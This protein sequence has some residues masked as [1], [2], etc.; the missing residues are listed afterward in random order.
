MGFS[1]GVYLVNPSFNETVPRPSYLPTNWSDCGYEFQSPP[2]IQ[3]SGAWEAPMVPAVEGYTYLSMVTR[4]N[5]TV[6]RVQQELTNPLESGSL[7]IFS[8]YLSHF[9]EFLSGDALYNDSMVQATLKIDSESQVRGGFPNTPFVSYANPIT[10]RI[11]GGNEDCDLD[12][13]LATS[14][15]INHFDWKKYLFLL[16]PKKTYRFFILEAFYG[17]HTKE[18]YSGNIMLDNSELS[19]FPIPDL[20]DNHDPKDIL[21][22]IINQRDSVDHFKNVFYCENILT[23]W[24]FNQNSSGENVLQFIKISTESEQNKMINA[25]HSSLLIDNAFALEELIFEWKNAS[26]DDR[27]KSFEKYKESIS[28][29][30]LSV[31]ILTYI[32]ENKELILKELMGIYDK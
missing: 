13:L 12:E 31:G 32:A 20:A 25:L 1:Q 24:D 21:S 26:E 7:Y 18:P 6:E 17:D 30:D 5:N 11:W 4:N 8:I 9:E 3:P 22:Y 15:L 29:E 28:S 2:D 23:L 16:Q 14:P 19:D 10:L 27:N